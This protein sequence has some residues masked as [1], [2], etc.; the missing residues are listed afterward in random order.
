M[1][2]FYRFCLKG[3][4]CLAVVFTVLPGGKAQA[5]YYSKR[6][7][8][9]PSSASGAY[10]GGYY[11]FLP[12]GYDPNGTKLYPIMIFNHGSGEQG[13]GSTA[14]LARVL[15]NGP[16][17]LIN[18]GTLPT[19]FT[20]N[21]QTFSFI[22]IAPQ[23]STEGIGPDEAVVVDYMLRHYKADP[24]R[25]YITGL[26][27]GG[28][29]T[30]Y[31]PALSSTTCLKVAALLPVAGHGILDSLDAI[32]M[33][34]NHLPVYATQ[35]A[36]DPTVPTEYTI[37]NVRELNS[38]PGINPRAIASIWSDP[39]QIGNHDAWTRT[40]D[41]NYLNPDI[42][43]LNAYQWM[44]QYSRAAVPLPVTLAAWSATLSAD[45]L[46]IVLSWTTAN[47]ENNRY[48]IIQRSAD[49]KQFTNLDSI[50]ATNGISGSQYTYTDRSPL[51]PDNYY[52]LAQVD[53]DGKTTLYSVLKV[54]IPLS[55]KSLFRVSPNPVA[56][57]LY[58]EFAQPGAGNVSVSLSDASG[59]TLRTWQFQ[60]AGDLWNQ[61]IDL[62]NLPAGNYF[63]RLRS[64]Q[65]QA[66]QQFVKK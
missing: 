45:H 14:Q 57:T 26:S 60:K 56:N 3:L 54:S 43:G 12:P 38:Y 33:A 31:Y 1:K 5:Q 7:I 16:P 28:T 42:G 65:F 32:Q 13:D 46:Q 10:T 23:F 39:G 47:E 9:D 51:E 20:V 36:N 48:F 53:L 19:S 8:T 55:E 15:A 18:N 35:N 62:S 6:T 11:E 2:E 52:R 25:L 24:N 63:M 37:T 41:P 59:R 58:L 34:S 22:V 66:V 21:G 4:L 49:G 44:L 50:P 40:Y 61:P 27:A 29:P 17:K 30:W 64:G